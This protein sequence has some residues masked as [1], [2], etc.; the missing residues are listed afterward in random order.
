MKLRRAAGLVAFV[1]L[2]LHST[3]C[4]TSDPCSAGEAQRLRQLA[5]K[6]TATGDTTDTEL[7]A[8][9]EVGGS[10][11]LTF[12]LTSASPALAQNLATWTTCTALPRREL[13]PPEDE[14]GFTCTEGAHAYTVSFRGDGPNPGG[15]VAE[16]AP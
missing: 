6:L 11:S 14:F 3:A 13:L 2:P 4:S 9:C 1:L 5:A 10:Q 16:V 15:Y 12:E 7:I 8:D